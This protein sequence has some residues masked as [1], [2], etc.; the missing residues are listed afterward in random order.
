MNLSILVILILTAV[1]TSIL[2]VFLV[3]R[4]MSMMVDAISHTVLLG[5]VL[6]FI[7]VGDLTSP[8]L[9]IGATL[10]GLLTVFA[11]EVIVKTKQ[12]DND[13]AMGLV[14]TLLFSIAVIIISTSFQGVHLDVDAVLLGKIEFAPFD[15]LYFNGVHIGPK[16]LYIMLATTVINLLFVK[17][18]YKE[19]KIVSFDAALATTL[20]IAPA[21]IHYLLMGLVSLTA[22]AAFSAV[23]TILVVAFMIGPAASAV[24]VTKNLKYTLIIAPFFGIINSIVGYILALLIDVNVSGMISTVTLITFLLVLIF[25]P[26]KG[27]VSIIIKRKSLKNLFDL[28]ILL[29]HLDSHKEYEEIAYAHIKN[30]LNWTTKQYKKHTEKA[31]MDGYIVIKNNQLYLTQLGKQFLS[32]KLNE[33]QLS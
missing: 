22:V 4:K 9:V 18:F 3:L 12:T 5:I 10:M 17:I 24:L 8:F 32:L 16:L 23:G 15:K 28:V 27:I 2:G 20:G 7:L 30:E 29:M 21:L 25:D 13:T 11:I 33:L 14:F 1:S 6:A 19:L 31:L 26:K